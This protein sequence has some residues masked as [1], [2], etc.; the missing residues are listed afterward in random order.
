MFE[1]IA[2][3]FNISLAGVPSVGDSPRDIEASVQ[4]GCQPMLV[5]TGK[6][7]KT[8]SAGGLPENTQVFEDLSAAVRAIIAQAQ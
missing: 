8:L 1:D 6:G 4:V 7:R 2:K 3:R 5:L